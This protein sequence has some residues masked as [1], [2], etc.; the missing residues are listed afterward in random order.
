VTGIYFRSRKQPPEKQKK[1]AFCFPGLPQRD[2][3]RWLKPM[4]VAFG[5]LAIMIVL[6]ARPKTHGFAS[7][8]FAGFAILHA[9]LKILLLTLLFYRVSC[10]VFVYILARTGPRI[11]I[12]AT[13][14]SFL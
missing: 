13:I 12:P 7:P 9:P 2:L 11:N 10:V 4:T 6:Y 8:A 5:N 3:Y 1:Q 14:V